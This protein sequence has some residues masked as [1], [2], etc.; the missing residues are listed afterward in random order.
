MMEIT[1]DEIFQMNQIKYN[2]TFEPLCTLASGAFGTVIK[3]KEKNTNRLVAVKRI[4]KEKS[5]K[6]AIVQLKREV[7]VLQ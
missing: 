5:H 6:N 1:I 2:T 4:S 3:A 7:T